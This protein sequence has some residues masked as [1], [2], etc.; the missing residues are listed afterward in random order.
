MRHQHRIDVDV[1]CD[2]EMAS[3][4]G[5]TQPLD[6][7]SRGCAFVDSTT[8]ATNNDSLFV[9]T[10]SIG[11]IYESSIAPTPSC[12]NDLSQQEGWSPPIDKLS[13]D[14]AT[15]TMTTA[16]AITNLL[17][18]PTGSCV[19]ANDNSPFAPTSP[20]VDES[21]PL[22]GSSPTQ[23]ELSREPVV[24]KLTTAATVDGATGESSTAP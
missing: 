12:C 13:I 11:T 4:A 23:D 9:A 3:Q 16:V 5:S 22:G 24:I 1:P 19:G 10:A 20:S 18:A 7:L 15:I 2:D 6:E 14:V 17:F 8:A 21:S